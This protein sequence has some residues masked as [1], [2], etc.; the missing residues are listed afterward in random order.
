MAEESKSTDKSGSEPT[1][2]TPPMPVDPRILV[3]PRPIKGD[4][5]DLPLQGEAKNGR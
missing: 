5:K 3:Q 2:K 1:P 4:A